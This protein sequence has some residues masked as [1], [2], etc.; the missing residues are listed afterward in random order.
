MARSLQHLALDLRGLGLSAETISFVSLCVSQC[1]LCFIPRRALTDKHKGH[2]E[3]TRTRKG[4][5][6]LDL[7]LSVFP[8]RA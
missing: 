2:Q 4:Q 8:H 6:I 3:T 1:P 7:M 5:T